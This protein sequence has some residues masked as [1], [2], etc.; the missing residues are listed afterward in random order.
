[1]RLSIIIPALNEADKIIATLTPLQAMR[2]R[3]VEVIL[4][5]GGSTD[6]T[7]Q[8]AAP[9]VDRLIDCEKGRAR[10]MN[11][12]AQMALGD[13]LLFLHADSKI[14]AANVTTVESSCCGMAGAFGLEVEHV[15]VSLK[16]GELSLL[17]AWRDIAVCVAGVG[18][19]GHILAWRKS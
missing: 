10:Q 15:E 16:M 1:M 4:V 7:T 6:A 11:F 18:R 2:S 8:V 5:D 19:V 14:P 3:G 9:L 12:G 17:P 13:V